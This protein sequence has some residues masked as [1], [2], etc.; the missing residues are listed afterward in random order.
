M[1]DFAVDLPTLWAVTVFITAIAGLLLFFSWMQNRNVPALAFWGAGYLIGACGAA[2]I[3]ANAFVPG[4]WSHLGAPALICL[5]YGVLW[6]GARIF[7]GRRLN[8]LWMAA[9]ATLWL[10]V[11]PFQ[12]PTASIAARLLLPSLIMA[13]YALLAA[14]EVWYA[15][16]KQLT[17]RWPTIVLI[18]IHAAFLV[19]RL[20]FLAV[21]AGPGIS[22]GQPHQWAALIITF[23]ALFATFGLAFL[24]VNMAKERAELEQRKAA[25]TDALTGIANRRAFFETGELVLARAVEERRP[26]A[27]LLFDIDRFKEVNDTAGHQAGDHV[28]R[29]FCDLVTVAMRPGDLFGRLGG[30][31]FAYLLPHASMAEALRLA[32]RLRYEFSAIRLPE[33]DWS[34]TVS[35][36]V[37]MASE[38]DRTLPDLLGTADRALYRAKADGRNRVAPAPPVLVEAVVREGNRPA[39]EV[40]RAAVAAPLAS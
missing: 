34:P 20:P 24:R 19:G 18:V 5:A 22:G 2:L 6:G 37:A 1:S 15:R 11:A 26:A 33:L 29:I 12:D 27:L 14:G 31:E 16:D 28:L 9:G 8:P 30:E 7:E 32:E 36:G 13:T 21:L 35:I 40:G 4:V 23:E 3:A 10:A 38:A 39:K 17:S 25:E